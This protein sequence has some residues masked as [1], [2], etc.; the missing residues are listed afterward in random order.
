MSKKLIWINKKLRKNN[1]LFFIQNNRYSWQKMLK[2]CSQY[3]TL[4]KNGCKKQKYRKNRWSRSNS[5][6]IKCIS[7]NIV[8]DLILVYK[9]DF[10]FNQWEKWKLSENENTAHA[11]KSFGVRIWKNGSVHKSKKRNKTK[12]C[13][14]CIENIWKTSLWPCECITYTRT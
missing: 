6:K 10:F 11:Y 14:K 9:T 3:P 13:N 1:L 5:N 12:R 2:I 7:W 4:L 8:S